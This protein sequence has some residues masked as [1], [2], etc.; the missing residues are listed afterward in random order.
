MPVIRVNAPPLTLGNDFSAALKSLS[1][2]I[3]NFTEIDEKHFTIL[4][5]TY[6]K[7]KLISGGKTM[8]ETSQVAP[9]VLVDCLVPDLHN[10]EAR[11]KLLEACST[12]INEVFGIRHEQIFVH[13][14]LAAPGT[15]FDS[16]HIVTW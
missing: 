2:Q 16:G 14:R 5:H 8:S 9:T 3:A 1:N 15:V 7:S 13:I 10:T 4:W 12:C 6:E 11:S